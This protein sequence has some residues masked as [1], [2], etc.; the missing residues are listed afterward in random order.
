MAL[1]DE[2]LSRKAQIVVLN[3][4]DMPEVVERQKELTRQMKKRGYELMAI[5]ALTR[6][7]LLPVL[8]K[9][10][11]LLKETPEPEPEERIPVYRPAEDPRQFSISRLNEKYVVRGA[12]IE[13]AAAMTYWEH[14]GSRRRFQHL[15]ETLG[16]DEALRKA[17]IQL[18]DM[19]IIGE[20][21]L[22]WHD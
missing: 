3:K 10:V 21:E 2:A 22:E 16:I 4:I 7:N 5:S 20:H 6:K 18:G 11:E 12:A 8:W 14:D 17:G 15:M 1:Y 13:R 9:A 19:V